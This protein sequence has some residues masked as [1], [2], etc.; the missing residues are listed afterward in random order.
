MMGAGSRRTPRP[1]SS[2]RALVFLVLGEVTPSWSS[3]TRSSADVGLL[4][5]QASPGPALR[6]GL[7][8]E[9][10]WSDAIFNLG[11]G[12][13]DEE[14]EDPDDSDEG[15]GPAA[16]AGLPVG[17][18][19]MALATRPGLGPLWWSEE[20]LFLETEGEEAEQLGLAAAEGG[21]TPGLG[22]GLLAL[23]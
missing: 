21:V 6:L 9:V 17:G 16:E 5:P 18:L 2:I 22:G 7:G 12:T 15:L 14:E 8:L 3:L 4:L 13:E 10:S 19:E 11:L 1:S 20:D 23:L